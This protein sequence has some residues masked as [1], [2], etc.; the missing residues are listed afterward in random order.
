MGRW[1]PPGKRE[2]K[3]GNLLTRFS[4]CGKMY[5]IGGREPERGVHCAMEKK[6]Q[7]KTGIQSPKCSGMIG[8]EEG[9][10]GC[11]NSKIAEKG[12]KHKNKRRK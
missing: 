8:G 5:G 3:P 10:Q 4:S 11:G 12:K 9:V 1:Q 7:K 2:G 6:G